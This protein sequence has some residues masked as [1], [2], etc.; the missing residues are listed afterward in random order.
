MTS[1]E[2]L[3]T[4]YENGV[5]DVLSY[6]AGSS[7][8][9]K[10]NVRLRGHVSGILRQI[11]V[12]VTTRGVVPLGTTR[13]AI[14]CKRWK[15]TVDVPDVQKFEA[16]VR[17][18]GLDGGL[19]VTNTGVSKGALAVAEQSS[20]LRIAVLTLGELERW[21]PPGTVHFDYEI[22]AAQQPIAA[23]KLRKAGFRVAID[24][25]PDQV[26]G[27]VVLRVFRHFGAPNPSGEV[28]VEARDRILLAF[29][30]AGVR[31]PRNRASGSTIQ[32]GTPRHQW[33]QTTLHDEAL[34]KVL[35]ADQQEVEEAMDSLAE[36]YLRDIPGAREHLG[37]IK[38]D[39]WPVEGLFNGWAH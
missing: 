33:I 16:M 9:V 22:P 26:E 21:S 14:E 31:E 5:A 24:Q 32:G 39:G 2:A 11:D 37:Y 30:Q 6:V 23:R 4:E 3:D 8:T 17:E 7:A 35:A 38:P 25:Y 12:L 34:V 18:V 13:V 36:G 19:I 27:S 20:A 1:E 15:R 28:Q 10:R 29:E